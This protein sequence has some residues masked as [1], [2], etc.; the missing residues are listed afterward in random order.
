MLPKELL[1]RFEIVKKSTLTV[2]F[3]GRVH[4]QCVRSASAHERKYAGYLKPALDL[5]RIIY[6]RLSGMLE[7]LRIRIRTRCHRTANI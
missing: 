7:G 2:Q 6:E 1:K 4:P 3:I 5:E